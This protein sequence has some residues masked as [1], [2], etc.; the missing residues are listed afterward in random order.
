MSEYKYKISV[1]IPVYNCEKY[2]ES[3]VKSLR[4]QSMSENDFQIIFI[5]DGSTDRSSEICKNFQSENSNI[6]F[7]EKDNGGVSSARNKGLEL[8]NGKYILFLDADDTISDNC[9]TAVYNFFEKNYEKIDLL[10]YSID[11]QDEKGNIT[12][13]K[14]F[15]IMCHSGI[16]SI[17]GNPNILQTTM[18]VC[19]KNVP[20]NERIIFDENLTLGE[21][22]W[23]IFSWLLKKQKIGFV[24]EATYTYY[25][26][27]GSA[28]TTYNN[29]YFCF[30][31]YMLFMSKLLNAA[32]DESGKPH[33]T[34]QALI[35]YNIGWRITSDLLVSHVSEKI[36]KEQLA[37]IKD[38]LSHV[39]NDIICNSIYIDPYHVEYIMRLKQ[40]KYSL[41]VNH[42]SLSAYSDDCL[43]FS[44][45]HTIVFNT[46]SVV[47][48]KL[49]VTGYVKNGII[50][51]KDFKLFYSDSSNTMH[52]IQMQDSAYSYYKSKTPTN[53][54]GGF[55]VNIDIG[56][57]NCITFLIE[58]N[59]IVISPATYFGYKCVL[60]RSKSIVA[61]G[62]YFL[63]YDIKSKSITVSKVSEKR[64][65]YAEA[66]ADKSVFKESK[67][68]FIYR[69]VAKKIKGK[70]EI[71]LYCDRENIFDNGYRQFLHDFSIKDGVERYYIIDGLKDKHKYFSS[72]Q[73]SHLIDF[74]SL[75][76]KL[77]FLNCKK[78]FT[79][80]NSISIFSPFD[81]LPL[82]WYS[83]I[84]EC[85][86]IYL[87]H[88]ILHARLPL[89]YAK[90]RANVDKVVISSEFERR[91]FINIY[92]FRQN[93][94]IDSGMPRFDA[95][96]TT[97]PAKRKV[98]FSPSWRM[99]LIGEYE[100]NTREL[101]EDRFV[102][103]T[104]YKSISSFLNS[105]EL[106]KLLEEFDLTL[107]FK[108]HP[109]FSPYDHCFKVS[110]PRIRI[111]QDKVNMQ[112]YLA[113]ITDYSSIVFDFVYLQRPIL[114]FIPD[115]SQFKAGITHSYSIL[116][117]PIEE[118]FGP[119]AKTGDEL[120]TNLRKLAE[121]SFT[122]EDVYDERMKNF[123]VSRKS[124]HAQKLYDTIK[125]SK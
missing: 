88:G 125:N 18:N 121:S 26:H 9:L 74:K 55:D 92:N 119:A 25:K 56:K 91:N 43:W 33:R 113:M 71:W 61:Y 120:I 58:I 14:R 123:F 29:P 63:S 7:H 13:H 47:N 90:E 106:A 83:D 36:E 110:N 117:L 84:W 101:F 100:N 86:V 44:Q 97:R 28:S 30:K 65:A 95:I 4:K 54:F 69:K 22:Q 17:E 77:Y 27:S 10:T 122:P 111:T 85:E 53:F 82:R 5:N 41:A 8:A 66:M 15:D 23:F 20:E 35:V 80:F 57:S 11:Y 102:K 124:D 52:A 78:I 50:D 49:S 48:G 32:I 108:N 6:I 109:I 115:Y 72:A 46:I 45:P 73:I 42:L 67:Q 37:Q 112:D 59:G 16:Y 70:K 62:G 2:I 98:L 107:D 114:Y 89:L 81:G 87:Q 3:C 105:P 79:S 76:H 60:N 21:D 34:A 38:V 96:D 99:N 94:L 40:E 1:I 68:A 75:K 12:T 64:L 116:D 103:S 24:K 31:Q 19:V 93:D 51:Y 118:G 104:F 39:D